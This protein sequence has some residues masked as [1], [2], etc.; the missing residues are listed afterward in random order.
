M[1]RYLHADFMG[2][3]GFLP[4]NRSTNTI[5]QSPHMSPMPKTGGEQ[6][7]RIVHEWILQGTGFPSRLYCGRGNPAPT[8]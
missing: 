3:W 5:S 2:V 1:Y 8:V 4:V 7:G 6:W